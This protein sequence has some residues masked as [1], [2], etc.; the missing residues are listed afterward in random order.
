MDIANAQPFFLLSLYP[1]GHTERATFAVSVG[2]GRFYEDLFRA[3]DRPSRK[4]W[5][6]ELAAWKKYGST[7]RDRFKKHVMQWG[8]Y[9]R[10]C[11]GRSKPVFEAFSWMFPWLAS[12]LA[13]R[14]SAEGGASGLAIE[15]QMHEADLILE[16]VLPR[17]Q[18]E[19]PGC[20]AVSIHDG[21]LCQ[22]RFAEAVARIAR[23]ET[24]AVI[25]VLPTVRTK[26][27]LR[28]QAVERAKIGAAA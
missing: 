7:D 13:L 11:P 23:D 19:L 8:L 10:F 28:Q 16:R 25:G 2:R 22:R 20:R 17:I 4:A 15:M 26:P 12:V 14:R 18:R 6:F 9:S 24:Q 3:M 27:K 21:I 5:G 1:K